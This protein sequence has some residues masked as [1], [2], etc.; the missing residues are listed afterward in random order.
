ME[1]TPTAVIISTYNSP[2]Y[3]QRVLYGYINQTVLPDELLVADDGSTDETK[4]VIDDAIKVAPFPIRHIWH[5]DAG[6]RLAR[7]RN[8]AVKD[9]TS[10]YIVISDGDCVPHPLL[11]MTINNW[12]SQVGFLQVK[13]CLLASK[14]R[15]VLVGRV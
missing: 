9:A 7:I 8:L 14:C 15:L 10:D 11:C 12:Q 4:R 1:S 13:E 5:E 2:E 3:L 6:F